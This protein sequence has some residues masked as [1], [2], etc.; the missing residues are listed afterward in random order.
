MLSR[1]H[2]GFS[3]DA[4]VCVAADDRPALE[5]LI[6]YCLRPAISLKRLTYLPEAGLVPPLQ[7]PSGRA[8]GHRVG[9]GRVPKALLPDHRAAASPLDTLRWGARAQARLEALGDPCGQDCR[10]VSGPPGRPGSVARGDCSRLGHAPQGPER[11]SPELGRRH[12]QGIRD[13]PRPVPCLRRRDEARGGHHPG[14]RVGKTA[15]P[16]AFPNG[17]PQNGACPLSAAAP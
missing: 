9:R 14:L 3:L 6:R 7:D 10:P 12:A 16:P 5:R 17:V 11:G 1:L 4:S 8:C 2:G 15:P 13:R